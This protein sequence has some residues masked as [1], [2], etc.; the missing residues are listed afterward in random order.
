[1]NNSIINQTTH[2]KQEVSRDLISGFGEKG[3]LVKN[4]IDVLF[5]IVPVDQNV[6]VLLDRKQ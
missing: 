6:S 1:M 2:R 3:W 5:L 4:D